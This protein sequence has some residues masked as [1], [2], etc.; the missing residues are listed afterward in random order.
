LRG[1]AGRWQVTLQDGLTDLGSEVNHKFRAG[2]REVTQSV[3]ERI[4][5]LRKGTEWD[6]L[7]RDMQ[8]A[9][10]ELVSEIVVTLE[11][12]RDTVASDIAETIAEEGLMLP[13]DMSH[14]DVT[15]IEQFWRAKDIRKGGAPNQAGGTVIATLRGA[16]SGAGMVSSLGKFVG[17]TAGAVMVLNPVTVAMGA[18]FGGIGILDDR[19][20]KV[21]TRR[22]NARQ[23]VHAF[24]DD[25]SFQLGE[26]IQTNLR[27][28][29]R[30]LR[31]HFTSRLGELMRTYG[32][33]EQTATLTLQRSQ[34]ENQQ[35]LAELNQHLEWLGRL[36]AATSV[37]LAAAPAS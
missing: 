3:D 19:N 31:D 7:V 6:E 24:C 17:M 4:E 37:A 15:D 30:E 21:A 18:M 34:G 20:R 35:R 27:V 28:I 16:S 25:V 1:P 11:R 33:A 12:G 23:A 32:E 26:E 36:E 9:V 22:N 10:A 29:N 5:V 8:A 14:F 2:M 13:G